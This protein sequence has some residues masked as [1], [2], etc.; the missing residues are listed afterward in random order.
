M[1][2][3]PP[4]ACLPVVFG[5]AWLLPNAAARS[6]PI[7]PGSFT[8]QVFKE[9]FVELF[10]G[11]PFN[12]GTEPITVRVLASG[13]LTVDYSGQVGD[14][15]VTTPTAHLTG[16]FPSPLPPI[17]FEIFAG[18]PDL[19]PGRGVISGI[20]QDPDDPGFPVGDP[21]SFVSGEF[22]E[23]AY[24]K[25]VLPDGTTIY[26]DPNQAAIFT[27]SLTGLPYPPGT[28]FVSPERVNLYLQV[29]PGFDPTRDPVIGQSFGRTLTVVP[30]PSAALSLLIGSAA[31]AGGLRWRRRG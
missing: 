31:L 24:F 20:V 27:A 22:R 17:P 10:A 2:L 13:T 3:S 29:G 19:P 5:L 11:T 16:V 26:S 9:Q 21:S 28:T 30:E 6:E 18:T 12:P 23:E 14:E 7:V 25:Q 4:R 8:V 15:I 1:P